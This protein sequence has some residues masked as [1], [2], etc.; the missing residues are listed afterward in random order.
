MA[1]D[2]GVGLLCFY[3]ID[4]YHDVLLLQEATAYACRM[5]AVQQECYQAVNFASK[6]SAVQSS[7]RLQS[8]SWRVQHMQPSEF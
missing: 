2:D 4:R 8:S 5:A 7:A 1:F 6:L 3:V